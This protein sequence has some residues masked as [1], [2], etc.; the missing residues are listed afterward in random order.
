MVKRIV[1]GAHHGLRDWLVQRVSAVVMV[2]Y[3]LI[4]LWVLLAQPSLQYV[5]W[6]ALFSG[7]W[8]RLA[9][10]LFLLSMFIHAWTGVHDVLMDY[11][12]PTGVRWL[13]QAPVILALIGYAAWSIQILWSV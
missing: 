6:K 7:Q 8:M 11:I 5:E 1:L 10:L 13:L 3:T 12:Q 9:S 2:I 4:V